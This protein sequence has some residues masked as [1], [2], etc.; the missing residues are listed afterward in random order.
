MS[1]SHDVSCNVHEPLE[2]SNGPSKEPIN[3]TLDGLAAATAEVSRAQAHG[4]IDQP[5]IK[6]LTLRGAKVGFR[7]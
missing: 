5:V 7:V 2:D 4:P 3:D 1:A 6:V